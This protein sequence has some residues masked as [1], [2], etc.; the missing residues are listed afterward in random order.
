MNNQ[1]NKPQVA[2]SEMKI[3]A[4]INN[5]EKRLDKNGKDYWIIRTELISGQ[6]RDYLL[7]STDYNTAPKTIQLLENYPQK[8]E[9]EWVL[10][11]TRKKDEKEKVIMIEVEK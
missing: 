3:K 2:Y 6:K 9:N 10:L 8:L 7:F 1:E 4:L 11:T 5:I